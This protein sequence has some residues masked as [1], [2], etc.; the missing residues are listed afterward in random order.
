MVEVEICFIFI[1]ALES[2]SIKKQTQRKKAVN[3]NNRRN[4]SG[5]VKNLEDIF[6]SFKLDSKWYFSCWLLTIQA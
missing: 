4:F 1:P 3:T 2:R 6:F 5:N